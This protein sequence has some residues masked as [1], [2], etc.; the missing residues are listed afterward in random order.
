MTSQTVVHCMPIYSFLYQCLRH[1]S[2][3]ILL[4]YISNYLSYNDGCLTNVI[5]IPQKCILPVQTS[6]YEVYM[7]Q[8][9]VGTRH[10]RECLKFSGN[11]GSAC[12]H[13]SLP[14]LP[15]ICSH[16]REC[17]KSRASFS[18]DC[19]KCFYSPNS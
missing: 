17:L 2:T 16:Y 18:Q 19:L 12:D 5:N 10:Y 14:V 9:I 1:L 8:S 4:S 15:K 6:M 13:Q 11:T 7:L 3:F